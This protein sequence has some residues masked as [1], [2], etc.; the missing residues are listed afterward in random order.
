MK[1]P[2]PLTAS[3]MRRLERQPDDLL[4]LEIADMRSRRLTAYGKL[5]ENLL[6]HLRAREVVLELR[7]TEAA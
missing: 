7:K 5:A 2:G 3:V 1:N 4:R 6:D